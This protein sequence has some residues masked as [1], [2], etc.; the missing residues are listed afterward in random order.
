MT[1][2]RRKLFDE[3][4]SQRAKI[5]ANIPESSRRRLIALVE[6]QLGIRT[7]DRDGD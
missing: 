1:P 6:A 2:E 7:Q 3:L 4:M 5:L